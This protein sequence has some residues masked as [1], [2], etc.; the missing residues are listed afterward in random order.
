MVF[1]SDRGTKECKDAIAQGLR[2]VALITMHS[3]HHTLQGRIDDAMGLFR[4]QVFDELHR[5]FDVGKQGGDGLALAVGR[6]AGLQRYLLGPDALGQ[7]A[8]V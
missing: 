5:A 3:F 1:M 4:V 2:H 7:V 8:G 6:T